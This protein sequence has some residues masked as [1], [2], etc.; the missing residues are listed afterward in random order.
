ME[1]IITSYQSRLASDN[2]PGL[3]LTR[4]Y[5]EAHQLPS[6]SLQGFIPII[7]KLVRLYGRN[8]VFYAIVTTT[9]M[10][11]DHKNAYRL[12]S[13]LCKKQVQESESETVSLSDTIKK[14]S[15]RIE[16]VKHE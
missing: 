16:K 12:L 1:G 2:N 14:L 7:N 9:D 8:I 10:E 5:L 3:L 15:S 13:Y 11:V 6:S 4:F